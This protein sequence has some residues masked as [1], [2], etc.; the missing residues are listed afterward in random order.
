VF[1]GRLHG[2]DEFL[3]VELRCDDG[4]VV[5]FLNMMAEFGRCHGGSGGVGHA[6]FAQN[7]VLTLFIAAHARVHFLIM[8]KCS[9]IYQTTHLFFFGILPLF[10]GVLARD[11]QH[12]DIG[13]PL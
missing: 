3:V 12:I 9:R 7:A 10:F 8:L 4:G 11:H 1:A 6:A 5:R 2:P 13:N